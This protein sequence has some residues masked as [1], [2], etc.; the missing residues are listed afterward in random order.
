VNGNR[1]KDKR[2]GE[3][4]RSWKEIGIRN[5]EYQRYQK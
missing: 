2:I 1:I 5:K 3:E 4:I